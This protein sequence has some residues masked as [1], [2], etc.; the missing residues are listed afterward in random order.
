M[1]LGSILA[2]AENRILRL[3]CELFSGTYLPV[4][5][6]GEPIKLVSANV[7]QMELGWAPWKCMCDRASLKFQTMLSI[8]NE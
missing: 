3:L 6:A 1:K 2:V 7:F 5:N 8:S 4:L